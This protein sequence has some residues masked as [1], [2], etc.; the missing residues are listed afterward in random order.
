M[1]GQPGQPEQ[2][3]RLAHSCETCTHGHSVKLAS[4]SRR[5]S[6]FACSKLKIGLT[7]TEYTAG[8]ECR[9]WEPSRALAERIVREPGIAKALPRL[10]NGSR[11]GSPKW[12]SSRNGEKNG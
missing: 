2:P 6:L 4:S 3:I 7:V 8:N 1:S 9:S 12:I 10:L 11:T 5:G